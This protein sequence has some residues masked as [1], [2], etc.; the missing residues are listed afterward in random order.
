MDTLHLLLNPI[1]DGDSSTN[2]P[3]PRRLSRAERVEFERRWR[4]AREAY[5]LARDRLDK[6]MAAAGKSSQDR[7][8][9]TYGPRAEASSELGVSPKRTKDQAQSAGAQLQPG[10]RVRVTNAKTGEAY[11]ATLTGKRGPRTL[12]TRDD[13]RRLQ[14]LTRAH[15]IKRVAA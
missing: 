5:L 11:E 3:A 12:V 6:A 7:T 1:A 8:V 13:G 14:P 4:F 9:H 10:D 2:A 15:R